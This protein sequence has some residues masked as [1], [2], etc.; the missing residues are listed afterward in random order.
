MPNGDRQEAWFVN[1]QL[2]STPR[3]FA[4]QRHLPGKIAHRVSGATLRG[5]C[6][7]ADRPVRVDLKAMPRWIVAKRQQPAPP[8]D[9]PPLLVTVLVG[10]KEE[11]GVHVRLILSV[12]PR[13]PLACARVNLDTI[14][15]ESPTQ[16]SGGGGALSFVDGP[17]RALRVR[18][19]LFAC[20]I[21]EQPQ[22]EEE[23]SYGCGATLQVAPLL[24][25]SPSGYDDDDD[26]DQLWERAKDEWA[27]RRMQL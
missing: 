26:D 1:D 23:C 22:D 4:A 13:P 6:V 11:T 27:R 10:K 24:E 21:D 9:P 25:W 16:S 2:A 8:V 20:V 12:Q 19:Q 3:I 14:T 5:F 7:D 18:V 15:V 17:V